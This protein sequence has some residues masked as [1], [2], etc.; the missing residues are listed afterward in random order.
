MEGVYF[1]A[2]N[3][4][5]EEAAGAKLLRYFGFLI[6]SRLESLVIFLFYCVTIWLHAMNSQAIDGDPVFGSKYD[7]EMRYVSDR[8]GIT[9]TLMMPLVFCMLE[10]T[11]SCNGWC[12]GTIVLLW[13][14]TD[15][16][17]E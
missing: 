4:Q 9:A 6:P 8:S 15:I 1:H 2:C 13:H 12:N 5:K 17:Q 14:I 7:A 11:I 3:V 16:Q 10:E